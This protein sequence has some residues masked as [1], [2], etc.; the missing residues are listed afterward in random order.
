MRELSFCIALKR[1]VLIWLS[2]LKTIHVTA[3]QLTAKER[4]ICV[5]TVGQYGR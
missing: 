4:S 1:G 3:L 5:C 2:F